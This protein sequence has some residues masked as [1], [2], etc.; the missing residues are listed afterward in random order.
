[1]QK[2]LIMLFVLLSFAGAA[3]N[4]NKPNV[5]FICIDDL[6]PELGCYGAEQVK[7]PNIDQ[8]A[9]EGLL[10]NRAYCNVP[11]CGA[12]RASLLTGVL[13]TS[14][15]FV[16]YDTYAEKDA[17]TA[18]TLPQVFK[19][20]GYT[21]LSVGKVFHHHDDTEDR[22]WD[23]PVFLNRG[24]SY[25]FQ[26]SLDSLTQK[27]R[28]KRG[29]GRVYEHPN[30]DD[31]QYPDGQTAIKTMELL[32]RFKKSGKPFFLASGFIRPHLPFYA[33]KKYWDLY[34]PDSIRIADNQFRPQNAP[35]ALKGSGEFYSYH[36]AGM[37]PKSEQFHRVMKHGYLACVSYVDK[38]IGDVLN[39]LK[40]LELDD[41]TIVV[42]WGDHGWHLGEHNFWSKHNTMHLSLR[43][44]LIIKA[45]N[46]QYDVSSD[47]II[48]S[49]DI[50]PT[51]CELANINLQKTVQGESFVKL[52]KSPKKD[53]RTYAY[54]RFVNGDAVVTKDYSFTEDRKSVV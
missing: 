26:L 3:Q 37:K 29:R 1:M 39:K 42:L 4:S 30:V 32:E 31:W 20:A 21:S 17:P 13:P 15:R 9:S 43:V 36:L 16:Q 27:Y 10:F 14:N 51:L 11:V 2:I 52:L 49:S 47:A 8:L 34:N 18:K 50:Y 25:D 35:E 22:S 33:P 19:E 23:E 38:L 45:P 6:R 5:L 48:E 7:S 24:K 44:P 28:S 53:F 46:Y 12:S 54:S 41:N 40:E